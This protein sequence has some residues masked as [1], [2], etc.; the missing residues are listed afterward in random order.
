MESQI[1]DDRPLAPLSKQYRLTTEE[2]KRIPQRLNGF[3]RSVKRELQHCKHSAR[4]AFLE[5]LRDQLEKYQDNLHVPILSV[6]ID[7]KEILLVPPR[8][9]NY[10]ES[11][12]RF[13]KS[14]LRRCSGRS[15]L[16]KE[17]GSVGALLPYYLTMRDHTIFR[18]IFNDDCRLA[19]E[20]AKLFAKP[21]QP[22][23]NLVALP[24]KSANV[25]DERQLAALRG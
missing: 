6:T 12:F 9:N 16:P 10:L 23:K 4:I 17:F 15:K 20:F 24:Q 8:T 13:I 18:D 3:L 1:E 19:G 25:V 14:L 21:W 5:N 11:L 7:G 22:P 2:A